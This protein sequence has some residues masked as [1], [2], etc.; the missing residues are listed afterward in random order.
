M[1]NALTIEDL[2][3]WFLTKESMTHKKLQK[4][5]YYAVAWG[6][7]LTGK[8]IIENDTFQAWV[9]GPASPTLWAEYK[10]NGWNLIS[11]Y[12][13]EIVFPDNVQEIL[14]AVWFTYGEKGGNELEALS[15]AEKPWIEAR[16]GLKADENSSTP[17]DSSV[18]QQFYSSIKNTD[19]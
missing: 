18:M 14:E 1:K 2:A 12:S 7:T 16:A 8:K 3:K 6:Y 10:K 5:C 13:G 15:H 11:R 9:H 4:I 17:I 19:F